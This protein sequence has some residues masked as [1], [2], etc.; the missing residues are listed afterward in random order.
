MTTTPRR[1][2]STACLQ[3]HG[4][5]A[6]RTRNTYHLTRAPLPLKMHTTLVAVVVAFVQ[7]RVA[8]CVRLEGA[9]VPR[10]PTPPGVVV[11]AAAPFAAPH[12]CAPCN[13]GKAW[14]DDFQKR[15]QDQAGTHRCSSAWRAH[16]K[17]ISCK[18]SETE[19]HFSDCSAFKR[20]AAPRTMRV[21]RG[22]GP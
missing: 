10:T 15:N 21:S 14:S 3:S 13:S 12:A 2:A 1:C 20:N 6:H 9:I 7:L 5:H 22:C 19:C 16:F 17:S 18:H 8:P 11:D 4:G